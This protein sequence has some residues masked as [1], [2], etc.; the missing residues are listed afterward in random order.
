[1]TEHDF[2]GSTK[3]IATM[4]FNTDTDPDTTQSDPTQGTY[5]AAQ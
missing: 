4:S 3:K 1:M 5:R 2:Q